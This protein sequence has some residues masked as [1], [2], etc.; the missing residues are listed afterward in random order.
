MRAFHAVNCKE[1]LRAE[2]SRELDLVI[3]FYMHNFNHVLMFLVENDVYA[4]NKNSVRCP[5][6]K[7]QWRMGTNLVCF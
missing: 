7:A 1:V 4:G 2:Q 6:K 5:L 3:L